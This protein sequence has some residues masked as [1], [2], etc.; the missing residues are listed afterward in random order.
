[1]VTAAIVVDQAIKSR[2]TPG[3]EEAMRGQPSQA[4]PKV[5][6]AGKE[7]ERLESEW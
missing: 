5:E 6:A 2:Q 1:M 3:K 7:G 4:L